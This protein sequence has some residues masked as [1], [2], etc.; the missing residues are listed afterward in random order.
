M[1][2]RTGAA[3]LLV[4]LASFG[5]SGCGGD[6]TGVTADSGRSEGGRG[7]D[8]G[9]ASD[10]TMSMDAPVSTDGSTDSNLADT[11]SPPDAPA[12]G[13]AGDAATDSG[14]KG[15]MPVNLGTAG[16]YVILAMSG[17]SNVPTSAI[18][19]DL[20]ISPATSTAITGFPLTLDSSKVFS[21]T[22]E[23]TG[24]VYAVDYTS[25]TPANL[26]KA[27]ADM[28]TAFTD[29]AGRAAGVTELGAGNIGGKTLT[30]G[31][32]K[33]SSG[34]LIPSD[35]TLNGT[36]N[37]VWIMQIA[38]NLA[39]SNGKHVN[40]TGGAQAKNVFWEVAGAADLGTTSQFAGTILC[41]TAIAL[42]TGAST[43]GGLLAQTAVTLDG[44]TVVAP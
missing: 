44:S 19:G 28:L 34:V 15:P 36:A 39:L 43:K 5:V 3:F 9:N 12:T 22:P 33:W 25:P 20:G 8:G 13:D 37:D 10:G 16:N 42:H 41:K 1:C 32:Y 18:T 26:T 35:V 4:S 31:V 17:I 38:Q 40:L 24:K 7:N 23:V 6:D 21:T 27:V 29:A 14:T 11:S 2:S 30:T